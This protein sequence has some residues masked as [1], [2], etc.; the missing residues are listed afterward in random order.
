ME[1][2]PRLIPAAGMGLRVVQITDIHLEREVGGQLAGMDTDAS[3][4]HVLALLDRLSPA[5]DLILA[6]GD[7]ANNGYAEA[8]QRVRSAFEARGIPWAWLPGNHDDRATMEQNLGDGAA[9]ERVLLSATW[10]VILLDSSVPGEVG[11]ELGEH[12]LARLDTLLA[13]RPDHHAL[14]CLH[15]QPVPVGCAWLDEQMVADAPR[16]FDVLARHPHARIVL[17]GHVHQDFSAEY[18][19]LQLL[20]TP[21]TCIQFATH[22]A[23]FRLDDRKPGLRVLDL[24]PDGG[25]QTRVLRVEGVELGFDRDCTGYL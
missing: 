5:P 10:Q 15:H 24:H 21:S 2:K 16:F 3:F 18:S 1:R 13:M 17:W 9:M 23:G 20:A 25:H 19:G 12:E 14:V 4:T 6:T 8:Y 7:L 11:G 22:S